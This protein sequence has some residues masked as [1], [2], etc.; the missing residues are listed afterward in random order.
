MERIVNTALH[1]NP[2][3]FVYGTVT[4][5]QIVF[6]YKF[7]AAPTVLLTAM[8]SS[9]MPVA[10][11]EALL[12]DGDDYYIGANIKTGMVGDGYYCPIGG[13]DPPSITVNW[14]AIGT[15]I[16]VAA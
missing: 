13:G 15:G 10:C 16:A 9:G 2:Q 6:G 3:Q 7:V 12:Q 14:L 5:T 8:C 11:V 1:C 4:G